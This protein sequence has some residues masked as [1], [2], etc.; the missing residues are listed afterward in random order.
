[1]KNKSIISWSLLCF[2]NLYVFGK[3]ELNTY[4]LHH[5]SIFFSQETLA[6]KTVKN[7]KNFRDKDSIYLRSQLFEILNEKDLK[8]RAKDF[9]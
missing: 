5:W 3:N 4:V 1:M 6:V 2:K 9:T 8:F 7:Y